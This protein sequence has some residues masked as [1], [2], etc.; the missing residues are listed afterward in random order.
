MGRIFTS[1]PGNAYFVSG[2]FVQVTK[3]ESEQIEKRPTLLNIAEGR[4]PGRVSFYA[5][6]SGIVRIG[7]KRGRTI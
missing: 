7:C 4:A 6:K 1:S 5:E 2:I 3:D